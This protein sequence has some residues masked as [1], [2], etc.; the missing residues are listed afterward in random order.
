MAEQ[1]LQ[2][3]RYF[4]LGSDL[5]NMKSL[6]IRIAGLYRVI[7]MIGEDGAWTL[8]STNPRT[9]LPSGTT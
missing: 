9:L 2:D 6:P 8:T 1:Y 4:M 3:G 5:H 7:E